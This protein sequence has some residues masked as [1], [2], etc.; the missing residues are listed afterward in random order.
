MSMSADHCP[1]ATAGVLATSAEPA[2]VVDLEECIVYWNHAADVL[3]G[4][5]SLVTVWR[6]RF[7]TRGRAGRL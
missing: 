3:F 5:P 7:V 1:G 2:F 4:I 6:D